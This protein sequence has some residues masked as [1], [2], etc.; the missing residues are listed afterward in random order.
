MLQQ[1]QASRV[2][3]VFSAFLSRFPTLESLA[4]AP[5]AEVLRGWSGLGYNRRAISLSAAVRSV[6]RDHEGRIPSDPEALGRLPGVGPY[7]AAAVAS[8]GY[9]VPVP[10]LD[11]NVR[12]V[13]ARALLGKEP[14]DVAASTLRE[15]ATHWLDLVD[16]GAWNQAVMDLGREMCRTVPRCDH[17]PL[18]RGCRFVRKGRAPSH[19]RSSQPKFEGSA[20]QVRGAIMRALLNKSPATLAHLAETTGFARDRVSAALAGLSRDGLVA[21]TAAALAGTPR[22]LVRLPG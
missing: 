7:T 18:K 13:V 1:T 20:R 12:R 16:P 5:K 2:V 10:A 22:A 9:G 14:A 8:I 3:P 6:V 17:C 11:T 4:A 21:A 19:S 15:T